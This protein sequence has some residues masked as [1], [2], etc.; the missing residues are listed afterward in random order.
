M[1][2]KK[3]LLFYNNNNSN[4]G[5][6]PSLKRSQRYEGIS[7]FA[8][9][10]GAKPMKNISDAEGLDI[11]YNTPS[12]QYIYGNTLY[13]SGSRNLRDW[14]DDVT[15]VPTLMLQHSQK[16]ADA[17]NLLNSSA[18]GEISNI[19][20]HSL[21][22]AVAQKLKQDYPERDYNVT[23]YGS[24]NL[25]LFNHANVSRYRNAGDPISMFDRGAETIGSSLNPF[26][27]HS[28]KNSSY[29]SGNNEESTLKE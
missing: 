24:P 12:G 7:P 9:S 19:V 23:T 5:F 1:N 26:V 14:Y 2:R 8:A 25:S 27:A 18:G 15:K 20:S 21:G 28:Y 11:A 13:L 6:A 4:V 22:G 17:K 3:E 29:T 16:Y 10:K